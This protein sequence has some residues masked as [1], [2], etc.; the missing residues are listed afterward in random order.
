MTAE[1]KY[2]LHFL[3]CTFT[4]IILLFDNSGNSTNKFDHAVISSH[5]NGNILKSLLPKNSKQL[6]PPP[7][8]K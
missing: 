6:E 8:I 2:Q 4:Q 5:L 3:N 7:N 1:E